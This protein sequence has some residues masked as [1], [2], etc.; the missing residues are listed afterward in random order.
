MVVDEALAK[1][2]LFIDLPP[3]AY[4]VIPQASTRW[5]YRKGQKI[6]Q[7]GDRGDA[8][9]IVLKGE[10][11]IFRES[12]EG[13]PMI[14]AFLHPGDVFGEMSLVEDRPRSATAVA[15]TETEVLALFRD[16]YLNLLKR[17][18]RLGHNIARIIAARLREVNDELLLFAFE[19]ARVKV[20]FA[21]LKLYRQRRGKPREEGWFIPVVHQEIANLAGTSRET[22]TRVVHELRD[23]GVLENVPGGLLLK[24]PEALEKILYGL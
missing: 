10:V 20:A 8:L 22:A 17:F 13:R 7:K 4:E 24:D 15:E 14:L 9:Y 1:S 6:F 11:R 12:M 5:S 18:P 19:E 23:Q 21:L 2:P 16:R 3:E